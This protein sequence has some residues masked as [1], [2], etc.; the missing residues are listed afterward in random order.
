MDTL[1]RSLLESDRQILASRILALNE[2]T[3]HMDN[4]VSWR[5][6]PSAMTLS[7]DS[8]SM[9]EH[10]TPRKVDDEG[11]RKGARPDAFYPW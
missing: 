1:A 2:T 9:L 7:S 5:R 3:G 8:S 10:L 6:H 11:L 4:M